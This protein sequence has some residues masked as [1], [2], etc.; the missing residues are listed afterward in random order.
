M[1][2]MPSSGVR[3]SVVWYNGCVGVYQRSSDGRWVA[4]VSVGP[5]GRRRTISRYAKTRENAEDALA[6]LRKVY[7]A[8]SRH[9]RFWA[10]VRSGPGCWEWVGVRVNHGY[11]RFWDGTRRVMAS[12]YA[13]ATEIGPIPDGLFVLHRCDN[14]ACVRPDHLFLGTLAE[15]TAD[16]IGKGRASWQSAR[17]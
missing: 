5:R 15:N 16:M 3:D 9:D 1:R 8:P 17:P 13:Y 2:S 12:R 4:A 10:K 7:P 6:E 11:G 14:R